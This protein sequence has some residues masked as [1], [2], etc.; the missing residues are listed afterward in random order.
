[1]LRRVWR[2]LMVEP[3]AKRSVWLIVF[4]AVLVLAAILC[5]SRERLLHCAIAY[6]VYHAHI[7]T[8]P[9]PN[10]GESRFH[11]IQSDVQFY[12]NLLKSTSPARSVSNRSIPFCGPS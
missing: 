3:M 1:M 5:F 11:R 4:A 10:P 8:P 9:P 2:L 12:W 7:L 6:R